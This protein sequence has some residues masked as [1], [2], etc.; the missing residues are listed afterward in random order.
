MKYVDLFNCGRDR[1]LD[2]VNG[3]GRWLQVHRKLRIRARFQDGNIELELFTGFEQIV[4]R[5][6]F[7]VFL[8]NFP[9]GVRSI[10]N[11]PLSLI[12]NYFVIGVVHVR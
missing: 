5:T 10:A 1:P 11:S 7:V 3:T 6:L 4:L 12:G 8:F 2:R 9:A